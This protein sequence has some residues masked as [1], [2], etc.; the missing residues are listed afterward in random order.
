MESSAKL[1]AGNV[2]KEVSEKSERSYACFYLPLSALAALFVA[3]YLLL[4]FIAFGDVHVQRLGLWV[5]AKAY[6]I[7]ALVT[8]NS[9]RSP[10]RQLAHNSQ[11]TPP[12][13]LSYNPRMVSVRSLASACLLVA[14]SACRSLVFMMEVPPLTPQEPIAHSAVAHRGSLHMGLPDNSLGALKQGIAAGVPFLEVD[15]RRSTEGELFLFHDGS[16]SSSNSEGPPELWGEK[17]ESLSRKGRESVALASGERIPLLSSAL[18]TVRGSGSALQLD[19]KGESDELVFAALDL[20]RSRGQ[21][22]DAVL[23][24]RSPARIPRVLAHAPEARLIARVRSADALQEVLRYPVEFVELERWATPEAI[25]DA[26]QKGVK[27]LVNI[28]GTSLD[29]PASWAFFRSHGFDTIMSDH[30]D[31]VLKQS[32]K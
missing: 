6:A 32:S 9:T 19:F 18:D 22:R 1:A 23:Q 11:L 10:S 8:L 26:H 30:A 16:V 27:V 21:L 15:V 28:S 5:K 17:V 24:I 4:T 20:L 13:I 14:L 7:A 3:N 29:E 25:K 12:S 2:H 31:L